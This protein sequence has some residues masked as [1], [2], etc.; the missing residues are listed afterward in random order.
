MTQL[1]R[2]PRAVRHGTISLEIGLGA[3]T[4]VDGSRATASFHF[5]TFLQIEPFTFQHNLNLLDV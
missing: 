5:N 1:Y 3:H 4:H 2:A